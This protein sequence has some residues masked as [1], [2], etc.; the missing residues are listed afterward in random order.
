MAALPLV[1]RGQHDKHV[2]DVQALVTRHGHRATVDN[3]FGPGTERAVK[4][5]QRDYHI[6][7]DGQVG[8]ITWHKLLHV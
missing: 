2:G 1:K 6:S 4:A 8:P 3:I 7:V 5:V